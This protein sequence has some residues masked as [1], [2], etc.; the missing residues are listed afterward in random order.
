MITWTKN[1]DQRYTRW[2][3]TTKDIITCF[4]IRENNSNKGVFDVFY[5]G[6]SPETEYYGTFDDI[7]KARFYVKHLVLAELKEA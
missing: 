5:S 2:I 6:L 3:A 1:E 7:S 4:Y